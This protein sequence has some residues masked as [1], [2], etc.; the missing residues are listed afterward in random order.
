MDTNNNYRI[1]K[2]P[3]FNNFNGLNNFEIINDKFIAEQQIKENT[4]LTDGIIALGSK[5]TTL[6]Y[7]F[8]LPDN[9]IQNLDFESDVTITYEVKNNELYLINIDAQY[10]EE[11]LE[12]IEA[13]TNVYPVF[14]N[15][16]ISYISENEDTTLGTAC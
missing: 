2:V 3:I 8:N 10:S 13:N 14:N 9:Y 12:N 4:K 5:I 7:E 11:Y 15:G 16:Y 1:I 6:R